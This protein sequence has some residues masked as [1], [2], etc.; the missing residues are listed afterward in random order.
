[1]PRPRFPKE[2][3]EFVLEHY[4][5]IP[6]AELSKMVNERF[7]LET[8]GPSMLS[9]K[10]NYGLRSGAS[11]RPPKNTWSP[12]YPPGLYEFIRDE[13][14]GLS[15][16]ETAEAVNKRFGEGTMTVTQ[17][18]H[19]RKNHKLP[20]GRD[21]RYKPGHIPERPLRKGEHCKGSE[22]HWFK[23]GSV[24]F[25]HCEVG[26]Y[27]RQV[28]GYLVVKVKEE[29]IQRER[30]RPVHRIV[31][32]EAHGPIPPGMMVGFKDGNKDNFELSNL[33]IMTKAE[34]IEMNRRGKKSSVPEVTEARLAL[35][36]MKVAAERRRKKKNEKSK[37]KPGGSAVGSVAVD[38][39]EDHGQRDIG[40]SFP[41]S[42]RHNG[43]QGHG[44]KRV[45]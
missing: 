37:D 28:D 12:I 9:Y 10:K 23:P 18:A 31:W 1:M 17:A 45:P 25:N 20:C 8:T 34:N 19:Y 13:C 5:G 40:G 3:H 7:G 41:G 6:S 15:R 22:A 11:H 27:R 36:K 39:G 21:T 42:G 16:V 44:D 4:K 29:G 33:F 43:V 30:W 35:A 26:E 2:V 14:R 24:P 32:E 38:G